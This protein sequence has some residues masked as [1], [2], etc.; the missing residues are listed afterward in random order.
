MR[1]S[2]LVGV[3][4]VLL[5]SCAGVQVKRVVTENQEGLRYWRPAPYLAYV[6][7]TTDKGV[8]CELKPFYLPDK[9]EEYAITIHAGMG[10]A[11]VNPILAEG[12]NLTSLDTD[13]DSK[14][15]ENISAIAS[16][17]KETAAA[18]APRTRSSSAKRASQQKAATCEGVFRVSYDSVG[19]FSGFKQVSLIN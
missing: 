18:V 3:G 5:S 11:K 8:T 7:T 14:A 16:L 10:A 15:S 12:W 13:V 2:L 6:Q 1:N 19:N 9:S 17:V 4:L